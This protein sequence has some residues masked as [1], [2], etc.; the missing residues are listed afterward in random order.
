MRYLRMLT[1]SMI[2]GLLAGVYLL[3]IILQLNPVLPLAPQRLAPL[4]GAVVG[5][6]A[7]HVTAGFYVLIVLRQIFSTE[8]FSPGWLSLRLLVWEATVA[9]CVAA[10]L[11]WM[12][13]RGF[14]AVLDPQTAA[15]MEQGAVALTCCAAAFLLLAIAAFSFG[16]RGRRT[17]AV[18]LVSIALLSLVLPLAARG[19][20][21]QRTL[22]A[23]RLDVGFELTSPAAEGPR[24]LMML[25]DGA[26]LDVISPIAAEGR[27]PNFGKLLDGGAVMHLATLRPTQ[28]APVWA[29]VATGKLPFKNGIRSAATYGVGDGPERIELL[30]DFCF[31]H[32][33]VHLGVLTE[34]SESTASITARTLWSILSGLGIPVGVVGWPLTYP[35][36]AVRGFIVSD[37]FQ[38][39][40]AAAMELD[41]ALV[42][43][44]ELLGIARDA[45]SRQADLAA[46]PEVART[47]AVPDIGVSP[48]TRH[49]LALDARNEEAL[50]ELQRA[51]PAQVVAVRFHALDHA[52]H[53]LLRYAL[54]RAFGDVSERERREY[55]RLL[56]QYYALVDSM[57][58]RFLTLKRPED[59]VLVISGFGIEPMSVGKR[60]LERALGNGTLNGTHEPA[61]DGFVIAYGSS[62][63]PARLPRASVV[64]IAPTVL[65]F[66][67]LPVPRDMDGYARTDIFNSAFTAEQPIT[68]IPTYE[69]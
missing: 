30:P 51:R 16:H 52:G 4:A 9:S 36:P 59:L 17:S 1:N 54:P 62:V 40:D 14:T 41:D 10:T 34:H 47:A 3:L 67:G 8:T 20:G 24:V 48:I 22:G 64:D 42:Y 28:P 18:V 49:P 25:L 29:A 31:A 27:L 26:S 12:N 2:G 35:A 46:L 66:L 23:R 15:R 56:E 69:R 68:F 11:M 61:P 60:L 65:Y 55:G 5:F 32:G 53:Y 13:L 50:M 63:A 45:A 21:V 57:L 7:V 44:P 38:Q 39:L 43:P 33:M 37:R 58:G 6:Y 19:R